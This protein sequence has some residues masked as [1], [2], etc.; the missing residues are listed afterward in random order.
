MRACASHGRGRSAH[1]LRHFGGS[2]DSKSN[3]L[4]SSVTCGGVYG[5]M[6]PRGTVSHAARMPRARGAQ[7]LAIFARRE[8]RGR[9]LRRFRERLKRRRIAARSRATRSS[10]GRARPD[11]TSSS[12]AGTDAAARAAWLRSPRPRT[13]GP[14]RRP[15]RR[16][17]Y[18]SMGFMRRSAS[19]INRRR[20]SMTS[21]GSVMPVQPGPSTAATAAVRAAAAL[22]QARRASS[23]GVEP[24]TNVNRH[25]PCNHLTVCSLAF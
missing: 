23:P 7:R 25:A 17:M 12:S 16:S 21:S 15:A 20:A 18:S 9:A 6:N 22:R 14:R 1:V 24:I 8:R 2:A 3:S 4:S 10:A 11:R 5:F 19:A 13:A